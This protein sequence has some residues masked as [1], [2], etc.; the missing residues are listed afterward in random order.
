MDRHSLWK[1]IDN[2][3]RSL[4][5]KNEIK[6]CLFKS[7][8]KNKFLP[9]SKRY[10]AQYYQSAF[11]KNSSIN[12]IRNRCIISGRVWSVNRKTRYGRFTLRFE[13]YKSTLPG[14][15]RASW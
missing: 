12:K 11:H 8:K 14:F 4:F 7:I 5:L 6:Q 15:Q 9:Y 1:N 13:S 2:I 3:K 10:Q